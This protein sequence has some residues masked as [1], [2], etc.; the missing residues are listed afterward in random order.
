MS[1]TA[2]TSGVENRARDLYSAYRGVAASAPLTILKK[3]CVQEADK[4]A[5]NTAAIKNPAII[6]RSGKKFGSSTIVVPLKPLSR[7]TELTWHIPITGAAYRHKCGRLGNEGG[8]VRRREIVIT[9][10]D[11]EA[12]A[13]VMTCSW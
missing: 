12:P 4:V 3:C 1:V 5:L 2:C 13:K 6:S 11:R 10:V 7:P 8:R 9:S